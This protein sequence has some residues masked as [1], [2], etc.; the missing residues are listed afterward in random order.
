MEQKQLAGWLK[1]IIIGVGICG[2]IVY[3][4][5]VPFA[6]DVLVA[7]APEFS[8]AYWPWVIFLWITAIPCYAALVCAWKIAC[9]IG[10]NRSFCYENASSLRT[11]SVLAAADC[12][13]FFVGNLVLLVLNWNHPSMVILS[14]LIICFGIAVSVAAAA[15][16]HLVRKAADMQAQSDLTI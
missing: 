8:G 10:Q 2:A 11:V 13:F 3:A 12:A 4:G 5:V 16:S 15:L 7:S 6:G 14:L 1:A 9:R